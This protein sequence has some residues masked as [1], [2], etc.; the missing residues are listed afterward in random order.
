MTYQWQKGSGTG[1]MTDIAGAT[2]AVYTI[3]STTLADNKTLVRCVVSNIAGSVSSASELIVVTAS[4]SAP[5][6]V[7]GAIDAD[8]QTGT[9]F[10]YTI[11]FSGGTTPLTYMAAP[12]PTGLSFDPAT[13]LISG[14][15]AE[16][17]TTTIAI[18]AGN[19]AGHA[20]ALLTLTVTDAP[21][22]VTMV[23]WRLANFGFS[24]IDPS[25]AGDLA[26]PD[27]DGYTNLDEF[28]FGTNPLDSASFPVALQ[29]GAA[30]RLVFL[31]RLNGRSDFRP[32]H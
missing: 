16:A 28:N 8:A 31:R 1:I 17:G 32:G 30:R 20:S 7:A 14:I 6:K 13:G 19:S 11:A 24:A 15:P 5:T 25:I 18:D 23:G 4:P 21:P 9:P 2:D 3:P 29:R 27:G 22:V 12:L 10:Q 26:D